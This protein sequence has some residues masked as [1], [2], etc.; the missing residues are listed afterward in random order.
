M[1]KYDNRVALAFW[2]LL[3]ECWKKWENIGYKKREFQPY[4]K[5]Q[6]IGYGVRKINKEY[7]DKMQ[8]LNSFR[9][10]YYHKYDTDEDAGQ[11]FQILQT[12]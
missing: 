6:K 2:Q 10:V 8:G 11:K 7:Y 5:L 4:K 1:V 12:Q 3:L 9:Y